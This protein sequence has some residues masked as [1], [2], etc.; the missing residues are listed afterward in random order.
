[1]SPE[2]ATPKPPDRTRR[3]VILAT[4][5][6]VVIMG[7][8]MFYVAVVA[9]L[10]ETHWAVDKYHF[11]F[12]GQP[13][14]QLI[15]RLGGPERAVR[16]LV[17]YLCLPRWMGTNRR[18]AL[19]ALGEFGPEAKNAV[20]VL[21]KMLGDAE[22]GVRDRAAWVLGEIGPEAKEAVPVLEKLLQDESWGVRETTAETLG[23]IGHGARKALPALRE[24]LAKCTMDTDVDEIVTIVKAIWR[25]GGKSV[26]SE[27]ELKAISEVVVFGPSH[28]TTSRLRAIRALVAMGAVARSEERALE[29]AARKDQS[30]T[31]RAAA[32]DALKKIRGEEPAP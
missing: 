29:H 20:S 1:M 28:R 19:E 22:A 17:T 3:A 8:A 30:K 21:V 6:I 18:G 15:K 12:S 7:L 14:G 4:V 9:P 16:R 27:T 24:A 13:S 31:V 10:R 11:A 25:I 23:L 2:P 5:G 32:A 26:I